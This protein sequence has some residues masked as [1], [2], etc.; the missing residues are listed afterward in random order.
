MGFNSAFKWL[1]LHRA[2]FEI[3]VVRLCKGEKAYR[4]SR[5]VAPLI[6]N[7]GARWN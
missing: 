4:G 1:I 3:D 2:T 6:L 7:L 5:G